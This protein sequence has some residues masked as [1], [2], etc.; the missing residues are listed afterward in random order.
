MNKT[1]GAIALMVAGAT[2]TGSLAGLASAA[3]VVLAAPDVSGWKTY[4]NGQ[5]GLEFR[6]PADYQLKE[7]TTPDGRP[8]A[9]SLHASD[10]AVDGR[11]A[12]MSEGR[13]VDTAATLR[14]SVDVAKSQCAADGCDSSVSCPDVLKNLRFTTA[15]GRAGLEL[16]LV[17]VTELYG[18]E[19]EPDKTERR[20]KGPI[21]AVDISTSAAARVLV[22]TASERPESPEHRNVLHAIIDTVR[23]A[24]S[25]GP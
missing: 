9:I 4:R 2:C 15:A 13:P 25:T 3:A 10:W 1:P 16:Y 18:G 21:Y 24:K 12:E 11:V 23:I 5:T 17:E 22:I 14:F 20:T 19:G 6:Y 8:I 7:L